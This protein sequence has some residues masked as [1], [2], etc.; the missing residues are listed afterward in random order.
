MQLESHLERSAARHPEKTM[1]VA[2]GQRWTYGALETSANR[3]AHALQARGVGR[4]DRVAIQLG[5]APET[6]LAILAA[7]KIGA[8]FTVLH[9]TTKPEKLAL[10]LGDSRASAL[11][12][13]ARRLLALDRFWGQLPQLHSVVAVGADAPSLSTP[14]KAVHAMAAMLGED[15]P[16]TPPPKEAIDLDL[17]ALVYTSGS[18]GVPKGVMLTHR[19][20]VSA[21]TSI[22]GYLENR[23]DVILSVLP[24]SFG[25][26]L[27]QLFT[28]WMFGGTLVL[29]ESFAYPHA[30][31]QRLS[32]ERATGFPLV[33]TIAAML[34]QLDLSRYDLESLRYLTNA[35]AA[36]PIEHIARLRKLL[37]HVRIYSMYGQTECIRASYLPPEQI[38]R[39]PDSVGRGIPN[40]ETFLVDE[41]GRRA[42]PGE[43]GE[44][45]VRG[46]HVMAGYWERPEETRRVLR[47][48]P[49][50]GER[51]LHTGDLFRMDAEGYLYF[52]GRRDD[53]IKSRG[54][55]VSPKEVENVLY[56]HPDVVEAAVVGV[57]DP[58]LGQAVRAYVVRREG[59][60]VTQRELQRHCAAHLEDFMV[61]QAIEFRPSFPRTSSG[62]IIKRELAGVS[63]A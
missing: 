24:L 51:V 15:W 59:A 56:R 28:A 46:S 52:V 20:L 58:I 42:G 33:P 6:V 60:A 63:E 61:P 40:Q 26:G 62:K 54:E 21:C 50:P 18:T 37:P 30:V 31:L 19:N 36:L 17:A 32:A 38:D 16:D 41:E 44:L 3:L 12:A 25:Y 10:V 57:P 47:P 13:P 48:G 14:E 23:D 2:G 29:E 11:V 34:L 7:L 35:G 9:P 27:T 53:I 43:T 45:V 5:N 55:K 8:V 4:G 49:I 39:R 22:A 1:L